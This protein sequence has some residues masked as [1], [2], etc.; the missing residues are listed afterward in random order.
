MMPSFF[1]TD[2]GVSL[3]QISQEPFVFPTS[4]GVVLMPK[5]LAI[6]LSSP[7]T[8]GWSYQMLLERVI[9]NP[10]GFGSNPPTKTIFLRNVFPTHVGVILS[11]P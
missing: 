10:Q 6:A 11:H 1:P 7:P 9:N 5:M 3:E 8:W 4:V 2:V